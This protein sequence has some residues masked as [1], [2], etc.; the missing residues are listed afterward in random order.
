M[1]GDFGDIPSEG[2]IQE[3]SCDGESLA[4]SARKMDVYRVLKTVAWNPNHNI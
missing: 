2:I 1:K 4:S 3:H